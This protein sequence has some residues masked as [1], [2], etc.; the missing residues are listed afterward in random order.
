LESAAAIAQ[1]W[2]AKHP[3]EQVAML[4]IQNGLLPLP[5]E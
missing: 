1:A 4:R 3:R 2:R 5:S